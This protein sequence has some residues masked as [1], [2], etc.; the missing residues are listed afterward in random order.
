MGPRKPPRTGDAARPP[1]PRAVMPSGSRRAAHEPA[2]IHSQNEDRF[3]DG[4]VAA[5]EDDA[6][7]GLFRQIAI[8][9]PPAALGRFRKSASEDLTRRVIAWID[10]DLT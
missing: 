10:K 9:A 6:A 7:K 1:P 3:I 5:L 4:I 2:D 8:F